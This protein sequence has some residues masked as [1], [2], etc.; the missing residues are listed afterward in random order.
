MKTN[1]TTYRFQPKKNSLILTL[2]ILLAGFHWVRAQAPSWE[3]NPSSFQYSMTVIAT[4]NAPSYPLITEGDK[5][6]VFTDGVLRGYASP[7]VYLSSIDAYTSFITVY[8]NDPS[9]ELMTFQMY[10]SSNG[11]LYRAANA[12]TFEDGKQVGSVQSPVAIETPRLIIPNIEDKKTTDGPFTITLGTNVNQELPIALVLEKRSG[13]IVI[14]EED[15]PGVFRVSITG[16]GEASMTALLRSTSLYD[17]VQEELTF[18]IAEEEPEVLGMD[19]QSMDLV[20]YPNPVAHRLFIHLPESSQAVGRILTLDG[21]TMISFRF[22]HGAGGA[23]VEHLMPGVYLLSVE[24]EQGRFQA[25]A[26][27]IKK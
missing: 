7:T 4:L 10:D 9:G 19:G 18:S 15:A 2:S 23:N 26:T 27:F 3:I 16:A 24:D 1:H 5:V 14:T 13:P 11:Q 25:S 6:G 12:V 20:V 17:G 22:S 8:S 21:R